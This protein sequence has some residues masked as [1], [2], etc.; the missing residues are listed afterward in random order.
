M[1]LSAIY[2]T[3]V[4]KY[5]AV[6]AIAIGM[7]VIW[8]AKA[9]TCACCMEPGAWYEGTQRTKDLHFLEIN[10]LRFY[11]IARLYTTDAYPDDFRGISASPDSLYE[12]LKISVSRIGNR[13]TLRFKAEGGETGSLIFTIPDRFIHFEVDLNADVR[14]PRRDPG[15]I[16][17]EWRFKAPVWGTGM[18]AIGNAPNTKLTLVLRG[19]GNICISASEIKNWNLEVSGPRASYSIYG[20]FVQGPATQKN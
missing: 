6:M 18:F 4:M 2:S 12:D 17:Q 13:W 9:H 8:P 16:Y 15:G 20:D 3:R 1:N 14:Q 10:S 7:L 5:A 11:P 19:T